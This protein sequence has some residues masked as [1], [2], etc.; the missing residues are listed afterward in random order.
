MDTPKIR[1]HV[2]RW[3]DAHGT[4][5]ENNRDE[6]LLIHKPAIYWSAGILVQSDEKGIT[7]A[8]DFGLPLTVD[9]ETTYR[10]RSFIPRELVEEEYD[11][12]LVIRLKR[13][14]KSVV[15]LEG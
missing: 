15:Q 4:K 6:T 11:A 2:V 14:R 8:Q 1:L 12:G 3:R 13:R 9:Y 10:T 5:A 7:L